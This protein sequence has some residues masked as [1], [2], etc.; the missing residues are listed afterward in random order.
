MSDKPKT[1]LGQDDDGN[2]DDR[3]VAAWIVMVAGLA[4]AGAAV[5][6]D[7]QVGAQIV[8]SLLLAATGLFGSTVAEKFARRQ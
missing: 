1:R 2:T 8:P 3:R 7:S 4:I 6:K 5:W